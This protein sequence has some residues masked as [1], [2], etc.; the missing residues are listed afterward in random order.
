MQRRDQTKGH[1]QSKSEG[2]NEG[3]TRAV[4]ISECGSA[5]AEEEEEEGEGVIEA[6][7]AREAGK[8]IVDSWNV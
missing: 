5:Q 6:L 3:L 2:T 7:P 1:E 8:S 4:C